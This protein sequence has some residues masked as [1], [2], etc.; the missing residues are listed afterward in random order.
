MRELPIV[1]P[2]SLAIIV[3][4]LLFTS[5]YAISSNTVANEQLYASNLTSGNFGANTERTPDR[6]WFQKAAFVVCPLH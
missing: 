3:L 4:L 2:I 6:A 5:A 1:F